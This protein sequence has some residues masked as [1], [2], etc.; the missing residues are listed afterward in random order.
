ML[1]S[2]IISS[3]HWVRKQWLFLMSK[4]QRFVCFCLYILPVFACLRII[5]STYFKKHKSATFAIG[6]LH[7]HSC[8]TEKRGRCKSPILFIEV[9]FRI[10]NNWRKSAFWGQIIWI[11]LI[12][13]IS[14]N[15][16][17]LFFPFCT[18][19]VVLLN[20]I[21]GHKYNLIYVS[22]WPYICF[23]YPEFHSLVSRSWQFAKWFSVA[24]WNICG[25][26]TMLSVGE[27]ISRVQSMWRLMLQMGLFYY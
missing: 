17:Q 15:N 21:Q 22:S 11:N 8:T 14:L 18:F 2:S 4:G 1:T 13:I 26:W 3:Q 27:H 16:C 24:W 19:Y 7:N 9:L 10:T 5:K 25:S 6:A 20:W 12:A 23:A